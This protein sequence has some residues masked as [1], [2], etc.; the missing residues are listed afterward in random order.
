MFERAKALFDAYSSGK[1]EVTTRESEEAVEMRSEYS[2][3][4]V[5]HTKAA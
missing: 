3:I 1:P 4:V 2:Y 5:Q